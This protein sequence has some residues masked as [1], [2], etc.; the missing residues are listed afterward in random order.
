MSTVG[1]TPRA[2]TVCY[3]QGMLS[4]HRGLVAA[5]VG[6]HPY[7]RMGTM[8]LPASA[9]RSSPPG[10]LPGGLHYS[11]VI[12]GILVVVQVIGSAIS[13]SAG[14]MVAPLRDPHGAF[15]WGIGTIGALM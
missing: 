3:A 13:Q 10:R 5:S 12:V 1:Q 6:R 15:G 2:P 14:I 4:P 9:P 8:T 7:T 11:W